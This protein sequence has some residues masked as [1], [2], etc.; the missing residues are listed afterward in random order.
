MPQRSSHIGLFD[1]KS[2]CGVTAP[3][4][5]RSNET[6]MGRKL[7][8]C[9]AQMPVYS[10][11]AGASPGQHTIPNAILLSELSNVKYNCANIGGSLEKS[12]SFSTNPAIWGIGKRAGMWYN[13]EDHK[14]IAGVPMETKQK[15]A[16]FEWLRL[17]ASAAVVL[18]H[19][20]AKRWL[21]TCIY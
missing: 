10:N 12:L 19:T 7:H 20:A 8:T 4:V 5:I 2:D 17:L 16:Y 14:W 1:A 18:M 21:F 3:V 6:P 11:A 13:T 9:P 15:T